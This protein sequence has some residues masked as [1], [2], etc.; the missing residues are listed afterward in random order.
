MFRKRYTIQIVVDLPVKGPLSDPSRFVKVKENDSVTKRS[1]KITNTETLEE[2]WLPH[3][4]QRAEEKTVRDLFRVLVKKLELP[5]M[6]ITCSPSYDWN[7][8][9]DLIA[10]GLSVHI[11]PSGRV[12]TKLR[13]KFNLDKKDDEDP[14]HKWDCKCQPCKELRKVSIDLHVN[15]DGIIDWESEK[16][17]RNVG[18]I[19][20]PEMK[21]MGE[22]LVRRYSWITKNY[23]RKS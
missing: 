12:I 4:Q 19:A 7:A 6:N 15:K 10:D 17:I 2:E 20:D 8:N 13:T 5:Q 16:T 22:F 1:W 9:D 11:V 3:E 14:L 18:T 21:K 23:K